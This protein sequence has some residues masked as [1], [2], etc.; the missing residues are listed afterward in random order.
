MAGKGS[1]GMLFRELKPEQLAMTRRQLGLKEWKEPAPAVVSVV[2][3]G[4][5]TNVDPL[6]D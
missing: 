5:D 3:D 4:V 1:H 2:P 6:E